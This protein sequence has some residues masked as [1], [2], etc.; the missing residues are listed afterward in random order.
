MFEL[1]NLG[2]APALTRLSSPTGPLD[3]ASAKNARSISR[4]TEH[5]IDSPT[6]AVATGE[7]SLASSLLTFVRQASF[8]G[9]ALISSVTCRSE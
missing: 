4:E 2:A 9:T 8:L 3:V 7:E 5:A 6:K 1:T